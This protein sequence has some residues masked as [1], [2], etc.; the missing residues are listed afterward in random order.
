[1]RVLVLDSGPTSSYHVMRSLALAGHEVHLASGEPTFFFSSK[2]CERAIESPAPSDRA[3]YGQFLVD[4]VKT[5]D[6]GLLYFC[7]ED[8][9]ELVWD[10]RSELEPYVRCF[11]PDHKWKHV[12]FN[13]REAYRHVAQLGL[14]V[15]TTVQPTSLDDVDEVERT[16]AYPV[17]VKGNTGSAGRLVRFALDRQ[18]L[19]AKLAQVAAL[20]PEGGVPT[21]QEYL[22]G[23]AYVVH[24][25][26]NQGEPLALCS[27]R[28]DRD[29][30]V[31]RG[32]TS[33][34]TTVHLPALD[35]AALWILRSLEWHGLAKMDFK[36]DERDGR[37]K[38]IELDPRVSA[39]I[40]ITRAAGADQAVL[41]CNLASGKPVPRQ[42]E[43]RADVHYRWLYPREAVRLL[44]HPWR[45][46][47]LLFDA[48]TKD[49]HWDL[50]A[51]DPRCALKAIRN[52]L[53]H[54]KNQ[55]QTGAV[56]EQS[57]EFAEV[58]R[59]SYPLAIRT[60]AQLVG[61]RLKPASHRA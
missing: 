61:R 1:M 18:Q 7:G 3:A 48:A 36:L 40:D 52:L 53:W 42:L 57:R 28:K 59:A 35:R 10:L 15:P 45:L 39:S 21:V 9:A 20:A 8:E 29:L 16:L 34:A 33:A 54:F 30:P 12:A 11:V 19:L 14:R 31:G 44:A 4:T 37:F 38:F 13:K 50:D 46:P 55:V 41:L 22:P 25:L 32:V 51:R 23:P 17:V 43:Y 56:W 6:Y 58:E 5:G 27:H 26:F 47:Q 2:Y 60:P 24:A 49:C